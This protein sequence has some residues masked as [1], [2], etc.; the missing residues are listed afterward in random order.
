MTTGSTPALLQT[1]PS[2]FPSGP[3]AVKAL[4]D[5]KGEG[6]PGQGVDEIIA[7]WLTLALAEWCVCGGAGVVGSSTQQYVKL[8]G[9]MS[10]LLPC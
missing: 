6:A 2:V 10:N 8:Q 3:V 4:T 9:E 1:Q 5:S 7:S